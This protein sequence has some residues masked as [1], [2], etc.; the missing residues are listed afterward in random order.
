MQIKEI[1]TVEEIAKSYDVLIQIY[2]NL[3]HETY[4]NDVLK[5]MEEGHKMAG[6]FEDGNNE[7][8]IGIINIRIVHK[9]HYGKS[10][11]IEDF[12]IDR[13]RRG[14]G[15]GKMLMRWAEWQ[16]VTFGCQNIIGI[17]ESKRLPSQKVY[18]REH[19]EIEGLFFKKSS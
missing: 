12:M 19:F 18:S 9:I 6:V 8:C 1:Q 10:I 2:E 11:E 13:Q 14:I 7:K 15:V 4:I 16:S 17:L 5:M 3:E